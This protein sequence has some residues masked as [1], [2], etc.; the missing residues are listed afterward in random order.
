ML[1][2]LVSNPLGMAFASMF[3]LAGWALFGVL[4]TAFVRWGLANDRRA[5]T[6]GLRAPARWPSPNINAAVD[7]GPPGA[8]VWPFPEPMECAQ[9]LG[10]HGRRN[11]PVPGGRRSFYQSCPHPRKRAG[12][13]RRCGI[14]GRRHVPA[15]VDFP[16]ETSAK[17][18]TPHLRSSRVR[19]PD[20]RRPPRWPLL[21][22]PWTSPAS[23][24]SRIALA[25]HAVGRGSDHQTPPSNPAGNPASRPRSKVT[26]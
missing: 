21:R 19:S 10:H 7:S 23:R 18:P 25:N 6:A 2:V 8:R 1:I 13:S 26:L 16:R 12:P 15:G 17:L 11:A 14:C 24:A 20:S 22:S 9:Q 5:G 4:A 3:T